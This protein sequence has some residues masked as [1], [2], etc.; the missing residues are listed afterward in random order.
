[1]LA[2]Q[3][4]DVF[5]SAIAFSGY[6]QA[7]LRNSETP[8][9]WRVYGGNP[10][11]E[12][13]NS[14]VE[15]ARRVPSVLAHNLLLILSANPNEAFYGPQYAMLATAAHDAGIPVALFPTPLGHHWTAIRYQAPAV[16]A[17][18]GERWAA[19]GVFA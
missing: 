6:A 16:L 7:G 13:A 17:T 3:H 9:A 11:L 14:P 8:N 15:L 19:L 10:A 5:E 12:A 2:L 18:L 1:M 4:P